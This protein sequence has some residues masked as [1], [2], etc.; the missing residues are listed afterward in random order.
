MIDTKKSSSQEQQDAEAHIARLVE[1]WL[2][3]SLEK[4][5][6]VFLS[7]GVYIEPDMYSEKEKVICEIYA[8]IGNL[9]VGQ[10][11]KI[12]QDILKMLLL[13]KSMGVTYRKILVVVDDR[14]KKYLQ[15]KSFIAES[16]RQFGIEVK[17]IF[18]SEE[19]YESI[20]KAQ[21]RQVMINAN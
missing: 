15:G 14:V 21:S 20:F 1:A 10:Q 18:L 2:G 9:K 4:N 6:K 3:F 7:D 17:Q 12:S 8:H 13:E 19:M 11:H 16:I 5:T